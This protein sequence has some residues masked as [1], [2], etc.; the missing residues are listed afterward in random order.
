MYEQYQWLSSNIQGY[1]NSLRGLLAKPILARSL[2]MAPFPSESTLVGLTAILCPT[3]HHLD[4]HTY[5]DPAGTLISWGFHRTAWY[6]CGQLPPYDCP[7]DFTRDRGYYGPYGYCWSPC[8]RDQGRTA[9]GSSYFTIQ[10]GEPN[11]EVYK[12]SWPS[13]WPYWYWDA[14]VLWWHLT[15]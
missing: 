8:F 12:G 3:I 1:E 2:I 6:A 15:Y 9:A 7:N 14:Y 4:T 10:Y 13:W 11:P 5:T